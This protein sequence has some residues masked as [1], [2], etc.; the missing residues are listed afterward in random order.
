MSRVGRKPIDIPANVKVEIKNG[1]VAVQGT[2][3]QLSG[4]VHPRIT[5]EVKGAQ[6]IVTRPSDNKMDKSLHGLTRNLIY[7]MV[8]GV[9][10]GFSKELEIRG[11][12]FRAQSDAKTLTMQLGF[13]HPVV[14]AIPEGIIVEVPKPTQLI[15]RGADKQKVGQAAAEIRAFYK[16]EPYKG[17]GIRYKDEY[18]RHKVGKAVA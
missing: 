8:K 4:R 6:I 7:N 16:P 1:E 13:S 15:V 11:V 2:R 3:G 5:A 17:T 14:F 10:D 12:G 9:S 18:V